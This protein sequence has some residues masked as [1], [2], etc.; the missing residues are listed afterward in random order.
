MKTD[1]A[2]YPEIREEIVQ[3]LKGMSQFKDMNFAGSTVGALVDAL[4]YVSLNLM[5]YANFSIQE[6]FLES[7]KLRSSVVS[8]AKPLGYFPYQYTASK[9]KVRLTFTGKDGV[10]KYSVIPEGTRFLGHSDN[11][12]T[13][14][15][16]L[17]SPAYFEE[18]NGFLVAECELLQG[19]YIEDS[20]TQNSMES[21][22]AILYNPVDV[23]TL[24]VYM[25]IEEDVVR[26]QK[27]T[28]ISQFSKDST[29]YYLQESAGGVEV[30]FGDGVMSRKWKEGE[31]VRVRYLTT[32]GESGN[33]IVTF[34]IL[35]NILGFSPS[36][37]R[38]EVLEASSGGS[39]RED[40]DS[41]KFNAPKYFQ[42]QDRNVS[43]DDYTVDILAKFG[44]L[45]KGLNVWGGEDNDPPAY[46]YVY[47][48]VLPKNGTKLSTV[49]KKEIEDELQKHNLPCIKTKVVD[50]TFLNL[51]MDINVSWYSN[52]SLYTMKD[53]IAMCREEV[54]RQFSSTFSGFRGYY[55]DA[56]LIRV[57]MDLDPNISDVQIS[58]RLSQ[59]LNVW[60][61]KTMSYEVVFQNPIAPGSLVIGTWNRTKGLTNDTYKI[62]DDGQ[63]LLWGVGED[64]TRSTTSVG[65]VNYNTG[66][67]L[68]SN[69]DFLVSRNQEVEV[70]CIPAS[71][72]IQTFR[73]Y[74]LNLKY[75]DKDPAITVKV[76]NL[77]AMIY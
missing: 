76:N 12:E 17:R 57:L 16:V 56:R 52:G 27:A 40:I 13:Y 3:V 44:G 37:Y 72:T 49:S 32:S 45:I 14:Q 5:Y 39:N 2:T 73:D 41:I 69:Y 74:M 19:Y 36:S 70:S 48:A 75:T 4:A 50:P 33:N 29:L 47:A 24:E 64:L 1:N 7:A 66:K 71:T 22:R 20:W 59:S 54:V 43:V 23:S 15:F 65:T 31:S 67:V 28:E 51:E 68:V 38:M 58:K 25:G 35:D 6:C 21:E 18:V 42:R 63:G 61:D 53:I 11:E 10:T 77:S 55:Q 26:F 9:A 46:G 8:Q 60:A 62:V 30:Y 34:T